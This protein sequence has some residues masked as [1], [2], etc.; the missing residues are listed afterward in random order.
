L[1]SDVPATFA[2]DIAIPHFSV[3][4]SD[5]RSQQL[6]HTFGLA[7]ASSEQLQLCQ[8]FTIKAFGPFQASEFQ[9]DVVGQ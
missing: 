9:V 6:H 7:S 5:F 1:R 3:H 8:D 2:F 4:V